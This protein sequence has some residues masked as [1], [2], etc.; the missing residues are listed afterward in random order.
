MTD[1]DVMMSI[2]RAI[3]RG[4]LSEVTDLIADDKARLSM[5][6]PFGTWL[7]D[8]ASFGRLDIVLWLISHGLDL[9][10]FN[11]ST[12]VRPIEKAAG[13]GHVDV[14]KCLINAGASLDVS[15]SVR[16][17]LLAAI[18]GGLGESHTAVAKVLI[19]SGI[20]TTK[21]YPHLHNMDA[22]D[23]AKEWGRIDIVNLLS[24]RQSE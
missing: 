19:D 10:A 13:E 14:V 7:H 21:R 1:N 2:H 24:T 16:N 12:E 17:P 4:D 6:T 15:D 5:W 11:E 20:D 18:T 3:K 23:Y 22:L 8:A 9:D